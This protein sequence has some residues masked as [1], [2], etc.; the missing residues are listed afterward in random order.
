M[1]AVVVRVEVP[2][3]KRTMDETDTFEVTVVYGK[4]YPIF[5]ESISGALG[6][7]DKLTVTKTIVGY[8]V[9]KVKRNAFINYRPAIGEQIEVKFA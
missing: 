8:G 6:V 9:K 5:D 4:R 3:I 1:K 7:E 2:K